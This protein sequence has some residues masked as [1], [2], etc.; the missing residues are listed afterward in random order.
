LDYNNGNRVFLRGPCRD[1]IS[2]GKSEFIVSSAPEAVKKGLERVRL[3]K[4][5]LLED[6]ARKRLVKTQQAGKGLVGD[7]VVFELCR[8]AVAL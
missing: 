3:K 1:V 5:P 6:V 8:L 7:L 4:S 2:K